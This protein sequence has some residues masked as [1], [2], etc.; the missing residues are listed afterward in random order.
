MNILKLR[1][2]SAEPPHTERTSE[3]T[4]FLDLT[5]LLDLFWQI[6]FGLVWVVDLICLINLADL[7]LLIWCIDLIYVIWFL[8]SDLSWSVLWSN[9][10]SDLIDLNFELMSLSET[11]K[12]NFPSWCVWCDSFFLIRLNWSVHLSVLTDFFDWITQVVWFALFCFDCILFDPICFDLR[13]FDLI[14][15]IWLFWSD[16]LKWLFWSG[17]FHVVLQNW[18]F[19]S[20]FLAVWFREAVLLPACSLLSPWPEVSIW[21]VFCYLF[22]LIICKAVFISFSVFQI[23]QCDLL[24]RFLWSESLWSGV[25]NLIWLINLLSAMLW[26]FDRLFLSI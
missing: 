3:K 11:F 9:L 10:G 24:I 15:L 17:V 25:W 19:G 20:I 13:L 16:V 21:C 7:V 1:M 5:W 6:C 22:D 2:L 14:V 23:V 18:V 26:G 8:C 12:L 4:N